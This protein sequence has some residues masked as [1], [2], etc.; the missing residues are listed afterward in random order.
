M[1]ARLAQQVDPEMNL[2]IVLAPRP[3][4]EI[5]SELSPSSY[6]PERDPPEPEP[7]W[8]FATEAKTKFPVMLPDDK[9][10]AAT[11]RVTATHLELASVP[12]S[13]DPQLATV[14]DS[15]VR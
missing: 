11:L 7:V 6:Q 12:G 10:V 8:L 5:H 9:P 3:G 4:P 1:H 13:S 14:Y 15:K 2:P